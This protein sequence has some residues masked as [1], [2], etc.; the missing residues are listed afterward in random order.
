MEGGR[1]G[2][3]HLDLPSQDMSK[4]PSWLKITKTLVPDLVIRNPKVNYMTC[5]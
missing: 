5:T 2:L 4:V 3:I 1:E